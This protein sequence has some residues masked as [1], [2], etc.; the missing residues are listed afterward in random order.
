M[1]VGRQGVNSLVTVEQVDLRHP[2][3]V[4]APWKFE[5]KTAL[6]EICDD[7]VVLAPDTRAEP[8]P[9]TS[10]RYAELYE[11]YLQTDS[12]LRPLNQH[13]LGSHP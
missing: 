3:A 13:P 9:Q 4:I 1:S 6:E 11:R 5:G 10:L 12:M 8:D 2:T 7:Y